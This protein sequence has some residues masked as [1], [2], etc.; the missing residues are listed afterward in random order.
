MI[1]NRQIGRIGRMKTTRSSSYSFII[2]T[3]TEGAASEEVRNTFGLIDNS[4][5][6]TTIELVLNF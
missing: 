3:E 2:A 4:S 1:D 5:L 6:R